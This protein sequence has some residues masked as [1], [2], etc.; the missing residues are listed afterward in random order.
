MPSPPKDAPCD[1]ETPLLADA[2]APTS[3]SS[4]GSTCR[5]KRN[6]PTPLPRFQISILLLFQ[7][8]EPM[9][10]HVIYPFINQVCCDGRRR[11]EFVVLRLTSRVANFRTGYNSR[12]Q[13]KGRLLCW[14]HS[15]YF[16]RRRGNDYYVLGAF[17]GP[18]GS[19][20]VQ[21]EVTTQRDTQNWP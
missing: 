11:E 6:G 21:L 5:K 20:I 10:S 16:L 14:T 19:L 4:P 18:V 12:R 9:S 7:L 13:K 17:I 1:E 15:I 8:A 2:G 3:P